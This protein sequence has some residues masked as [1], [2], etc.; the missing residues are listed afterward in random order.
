MFKLQ[1]QMQGLLLGRGG[2]GP[3][4]Q[5]WVFDDELGSANAGSD[6]RWTSPPGEFSHNVACTHPPSYHND[7]Q[8]SSVIPDCSAGL[9]FYLGISIM[10]SIQQVQVF[11]QTIRMKEISRYRVSLSSAGNGNIISF[12]TLPASPRHPY[13]GVSHKTNIAIMCS[14]SSKIRPFF[15][16]PKTNREQFPRVER[17]FP[18][19]F[20]VGARFD[21]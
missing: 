2:T 13:K 11:L 21:P 17:L 3:I 9:T 4:G 7:R 5:K 10:K 16:A 19:L 6:G 12:H 1:V 15:H 20:C 8:G 18:T 14:S